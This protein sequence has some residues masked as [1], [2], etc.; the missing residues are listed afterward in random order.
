MKRIGGLWEKIVSFDNLYQAY[1]KARLGKASSAEVAKFALH[2][3]ANLFA[4]QRRLQD[5]SYRPGAYRQF[6]IY[7]RKPRTISAAPF[8]DRV[9]HHALMRQVEP[10]LD[11]RFIFDSYA[12]RQGKGVHGAVDRYQAWSRRYAYALQVD[13]QRYFPSV[14]HRLLKAK[15]HRL[16]KDPLVLWLF[17]VIVDSGSSPF[18]VAAFGGDDLVDLMQRRTGL[19]IGNLTSQ[20]LG[21]LYLNDLD[22]YLKEVCGVKAYLRYVDDLVLLSDDKAE[23]WRWAERIKDFLAKERLRLH[24]NKIQVTATVLGLNVLGYRVFPE[25]RRLRRDNGYRYRRQLNK[26]AR[27]YGR[28]ELTLEEVRCSVAAWIGHVQHAESFGLRKAVLGSVH[29]QRELGQ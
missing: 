27:A 16:I 29:F 15:L 22:H 5:Q 14:D 17:E 18:Q 4:L 21:N 13:V 28:G 8:R 10:L 2:L 12:C 20:F 23:L 9:V 7:D 26:L 1:R 19:P 24:P 3:E 6:Q 25:Q 11:R